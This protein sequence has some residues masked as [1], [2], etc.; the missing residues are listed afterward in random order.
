MDKV[1]GPHAKGVQST[2]E[3]FIRELMYILTLAVRKSFE[4][5][6]QLTLYWLN[7]DHGLAAVPLP[8]TD[9]P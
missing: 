8:L 7:E 9:L 4:M 2:P 5:A 3:A 6:F 1:L